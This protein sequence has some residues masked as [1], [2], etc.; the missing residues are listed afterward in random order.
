MKTRR[1]TVAWGWTM[2]LLLALG[3]YPVVAVADVIMADTAGADTAYTAD[4]Y[5]V[6]NLSAGLFIKSVAFDITADTDAF[7]DFD[8]DASF[9]NASGPVLGALTGLNSGDI[10]FSFSN[11]VGSDTTHPAVI[12]ISFAPGSFG[13]GDAMRFSADTDWF[14]SDPAPGGVFGQGG[15]IFSAVLESGEYG[16]TAFIKLIADA[17]VAP[18]GFCKDSDPV[19]EPAAVLL[20][21]FGLIGMAGARRK[22][23]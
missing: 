16:S 9:S 18:L 20:L 13:P 14:V 1:K 5:G 2:L 4:Y 7:F 23:Q 17:S 6:R 11:F 8:G 15:A 3:T 19:P 12:K 21:G 10:S 22:P